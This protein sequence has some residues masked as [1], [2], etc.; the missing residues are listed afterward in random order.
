MTTK[1]DGLPYTE[2][3]SFSSRQFVFNASHSNYDGN[4]NGANDPK[5]GDFY[6][7]FLE[8][9]GEPSIAHAFRI[10]EDLDHVADRIHRRIVL[11]YHDRMGLNTRESMLNYLQ[12]GAMHGFWTVP[13]REMANNDLEHTCTMLQDIH[14]VF[15]D[16]KQQKFSRMSIVSQTAVPVQAPAGM[17]A[18][19]SD[20]R[21]SLAVDVRS[22]LRYTSSCCTYQT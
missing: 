17:R 22:N 9:F 18:Q 2:D 19:S 13:G 3:R 21:R 14:T 8:V 16:S 7:A 4:L 1:A 10:H 6:A 5:R 12:L 15:Y 20:G 11:N